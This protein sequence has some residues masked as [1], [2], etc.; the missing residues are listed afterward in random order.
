MIQQLK[1][2]SNPIS[3]AIDF[4]GDSILGGYIM[5][6]AVDAIKPY[7]ETEREFFQGTQCRYL[8]CLKLWI[9]ILVCEKGIQRM[10]SDK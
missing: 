8:K 2:T 7:S 1:R 3:R 9:K 5:E 4:W 6:I 10:E